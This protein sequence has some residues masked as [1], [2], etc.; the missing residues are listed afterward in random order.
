MRAALKP[1][2]GAAEPVGMAKEAA[3]P[4]C[5]A[6]MIFAGDEDPGDLVMCS[7]CGAPF[8]VQSVGDDEIDWELLEDF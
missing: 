4:V 6:D 7:Y 5:D 8:T 2:R 3:C 1:G